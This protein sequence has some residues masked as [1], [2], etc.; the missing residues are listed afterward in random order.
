MLNVI[1]KPVYTIKL[2]KNQKISDFVSELSKKLI[3][4]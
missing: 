1:D 4:F 3:L 2:L